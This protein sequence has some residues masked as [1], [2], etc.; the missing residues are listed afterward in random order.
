MAEISGAACKQDTVALEAGHLAKT[1]LPPLRKNRNQGD[2]FTGAIS[3][4]R[5]LHRDPPKDLLDGRSD[6]AAG[7]DVKGTPEGGDEKKLGVEARIGGQLVC[8]ETLG[9]IC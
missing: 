1:Y 9:A 3:V 6:G 8:R 5:Y 7:P 4:P 2:L